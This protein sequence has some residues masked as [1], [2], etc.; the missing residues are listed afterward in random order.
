M[1]KKVCDRCGVDITASRFLK[2][3]H[4]EIIDIEEI[5]EPEESM[6]DYI[7][8]AVRKGLAALTGNPEGF[9][10]KHLELC[11]KCGKALR[12][13]YSTT[14]VSFEEEGDI[15]NEETEIMDN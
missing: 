4:I 8:T 5:G 1:T 15:D 3:T 7:A 12:F 14:H 13:F 11:K 6:A 9:T 2:V 10:T